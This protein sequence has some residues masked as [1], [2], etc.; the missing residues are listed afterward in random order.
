MPSIDSLLSTHLSEQPQPDGAVLIYGAGNKGRE[1]AALLKDRFNV[2]GFADRKVPQPEL[3][4]FPVRTFEDWVCETDL[5]QVTV[6]VG[7][8][9]H[10]V[11]MAPLLANIAAQGA[12][13]VIN[14][15]QLHACLPD[16]A[17]AYWLTAPNRYRAHADELQRLQALFQDDISL[18]VLH[19]VLE[20]RL[21]GNYA[22]LPPARHA[23]QYMPHDLP[24][25][26]EPMR[27][28]D[29]GAYNGDTVLAMRK[30]HYRFE[31][32]LCFEPDP[33]NYAQL[34]AVVKD[35]GSGLCLPCGVSD[36][37]GLMRFSAS[38]TGASTISGTGE[39]IIQC[40][41]IDD[42]APG[43][44]PTLIKMD[45]EGAE[46][47]ALSGARQTL[48]KYR[49]ALA[50]SI[51]HDYAHLWQLPLLVDSW[52]LDY[53]FHLRMHGNSSFDLVLYA[54]SRN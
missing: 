6:V 52:Q 44:A 30:Q 4:G 50:L 18:D 29:C 49:P 15:V 38:G 41:T 12:K 1:L 40:V 3:E 19:R 48:G 20:F 42:V 35:M 24:R 13:R 33:A 37:A 28:I 46:P 51:Y 27:L 21:T 17:D 7:I 23:D 9:N 36:Q 43:F 10:Q 25:W 32:L 14:P 34:C 53:D 31:Q 26:R 45:V 22:C 8:H 47:L 54:L 5:S 11:P 2:I 39:Q 16:L